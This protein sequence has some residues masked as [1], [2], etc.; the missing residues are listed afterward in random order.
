MITPRTQHA[1]RLLAG[2]LA[3]AVIAL[4]VAAVPSVAA[5]GLRD[6]VDITNPHQTN[7]VG[8]Y[9]VVWMDGAEY[10]MTFSNTGFSGNSPQD[11]APFYVLAPQTDTPQGAPP[12]TFPHDH[13]VPALPQ[14][15]HGSYSVHFQGF[16]VICS[17]DGIASGACVPAFTDLGGGTVLPL[18]RTVNGQPLTSTEAIESAAAGGS[19]VLLN[20]GPTARLIG[21]ISGNL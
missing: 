6:C 5:G 9:E 20:L 18:A 11:L 2:S 7:H 15:N 13:V 3:I 12:N 16:F 1:R 14:Q 10:R 8:C 19:A 17:G 4:S 21:S